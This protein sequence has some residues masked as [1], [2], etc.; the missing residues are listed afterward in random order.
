MADHDHKTEDRWTRIEQYLRDEMPAKE[1]TAFEQEMSVDATLRK[2]VE[3]HRLVHQTLGDPGENTFRQTLGEVANKWHDTSAVV[4]G[5]RT[6]M[7]WRIIGIAATVLIAVGVYLWFD[8]QQNG[9]P[10]DAYFEPYAMVLTERAAADTATVDRLVTTA[11]RQYTQGEFRQAAESF[12]K[13]R[14][15]DPSAPAYTF[16]E[17]VA[18]LGAGEHDQAVDAL[19]ELLDMPD[20]LLVQQGRWYLALAQWENGQQDE[21]LANMEL[22]QPGEF[23]Y[24]EARAIIRNN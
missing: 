15:I 11:V 20:H 21:A 2:E 9:D 5:S 22:I 17:G 14:D 8:G 23:K 12:A 1:R 24:D 13:L 18:R 6:P 10:F 16:Y 3:L 19:R 4:T 7:A